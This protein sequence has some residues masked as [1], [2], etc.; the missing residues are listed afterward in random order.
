MREAHSEEYGLSFSLL[1][2]SCFIILYSALYFAYGNKPSFQI[3]QLFYY[4]FCLF[5]L[6]LAI[7]YTTRAVTVFFKDLLQII[8]ILL[9]VGMWGTP[10][11][12]SITQIPEKA[13]FL[14]P[15]FR[16][17]PIYYVIEG[18][19]SSLFE[20]TW[21]HERWLDTLIFWGIVAVLFAIGAYV[22]KKLR[23]LFADVL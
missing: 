16:F 10:I 1:L 8:N 13:K 12:W 18:Y 5:M 22:F 2:L 21:V 11:L 23:P 9:Q 3:L 20:G 17:N 6:V 15:L 19:R 4:S 7:T 14:E